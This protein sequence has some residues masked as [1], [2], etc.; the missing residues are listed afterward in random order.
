MTRIKV[1]GITNL[2]DALM[3][4]ELGVDALG[5]VFAKSSRQITPQNARRIIEKL[6][7]FVGKVGVLES[8][9]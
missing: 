4:V 7:P 9:Y 8:P 5:F 3:A 1:C 2:P 6:P